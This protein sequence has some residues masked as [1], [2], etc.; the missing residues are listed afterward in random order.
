MFPAM[1]TLK[2]IREGGH[3]SLSIPLRTCPWLRRLHVTAICTRAT[4][5]RAVPI[6]QRTCTVSLT[7]AQPRNAGALYQVLTHMCIAPAYAACTHSSARW[8]WHLQEKKEQR[9]WAWDEEGVICSRHAQ[10]DRIAQRLVTMVYIFYGQDYMLAS[11]ALN[12]FPAPLR[13]N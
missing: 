2:L 6:A 7:P 10:T 12:C 1:H 5:T 3:L 9:P 11:T 8:L 4:C 13:L